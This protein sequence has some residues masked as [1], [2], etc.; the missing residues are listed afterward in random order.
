MMIPNVVD[1]NFPQ[2]YW[3]D[4]T[5]RVAVDPHVQ[6]QKC[7]LSGPCYSEDCP[8]C[9]RPLL[10]FWDV[11]CHMAGGKPRPGRL[12]LSYSKSN[13]EYIQFSRLCTTCQQFVPA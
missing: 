13:F 3:A 4:R 12:P 8:R 1:P 6:N 5:L 10:V 11:S 7:L 9:C 2:I